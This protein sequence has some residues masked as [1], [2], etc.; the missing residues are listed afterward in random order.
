MSKS[1]DQ[2]KKDREKKV[3]Q[4]KLDEAKKRTALLASM[5]QVPEGKAGVLTSKLT[6]GVHLPGIEPPRTSEAP[7]IR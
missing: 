7:R 1:K 2:K 6:A 3:A 5:K 4:K